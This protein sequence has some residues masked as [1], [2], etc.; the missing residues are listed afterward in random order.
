MVTAAT[1][2]SFLGWELSVFLFRITFTAVPTTMLSDW[3]RQKR[4]RNGAEK[5]PIAFRLRFVIL[6][7]P[8][9]W[10]NL[11]ASLRGIQYCY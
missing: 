10:N 1:D 7:F 4:K 6:Q 5:K 8:E 11:S 2:E 3:H 9:R